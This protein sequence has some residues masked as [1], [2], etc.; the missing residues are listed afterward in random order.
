MSDYKNFVEIGDDVTDGYSMFH[1]ITY[2]HPEEEC[3][4]WQRGIDNFC[5]WLDENGFAVVEVPPNKACSGLPYGTRLRV[6]LGKFLVSLGEL[7]ASF[8]IR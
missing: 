6:N 7:I 1:K 3:I 8:G 2:K 4:G 5:E